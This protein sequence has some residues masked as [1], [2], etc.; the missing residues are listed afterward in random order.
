MSMTYSENYYTNVIVD[1]IYDRIN[2]G[3]TRAFAVIESELWHELVDSQQ[4]KIKA[5]EEKLES[6]I[7][8][9]KFTLHSAE[10]MHRPDEK[11]E[12]DL[13]PMFYHSLTYEGDLSL[14][15]KTRAARE[16][17]RQNERKE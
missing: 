5:L 4:E 7:N 6:A 13:S 17:L 1:K 11:L 14:I 10:Y 12:S 9:L 15:E 16:W 2:K 8:H 3:D